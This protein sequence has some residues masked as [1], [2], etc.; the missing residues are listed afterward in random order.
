M[1]V[2]DVLSHQHFERAR[3]CAGAS[4]TSREVTW[5]HVVDQPDPANWVKPGQLVLS[6]GHA[7]IGDPRR[8]WEIVEEL[9][10][11]GVSA[12]VLAVPAY[13]ST[14]PEVM[15]EAGDRL[16]LPL[17]ELPWEVPFVDVTEAL[18][19]IVLSE[20]TKVVEASEEIH[21]KLT[22]AAVSFRGLQD[23]AEALGTL[24]RRAVIIEAA[25]GSLLAHHRRDEAEDEVRAIT[26]ATGRRAPGYLDYIGKLGLRQAISGADG[27]MRVPGTKDGR[28]AARVVCPVKLMSETVGY[29]W[30]I[31]GEAPL[32]DLDLRAAEHAATVAALHI[33]HQRELW[34]TERRLGSTLVDTLLELRGAPESG[35]LERARLEGLTEGSSWRLL[36]FVLALP[37]PLEEAGLRTRDRVASRLRSRLLDEGSFGLVTTS[38][39]FVIAIA[40]E[41][42][43]AERILGDLGLTDITVLVSARGTSLDDVRKRYLELQE[44]LPHVH[45]P[46]VHRHDDYLL[47]RVLAGERQAQAELMK[48][49]LGGLCDV[50]GGDTLLRTLRELCA[51][52]FQLNQAASKLGIHI[53]TLR[54][55]LERLNDLLGHDLNDS[56][57]RFLLQLSFAIL[58][59]GQS[60]E[61]AAGP[62]G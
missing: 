18:H 54:Y 7:F 43:E 20:Q 1:R 6:T 16:G 23:L 33:S 26:I 48:R 40:P 29:V 14:F 27:P 32:T 28:I 38:L 42:V 11:I 21:R 19:R 59:Y 45:V 24:L 22:R 31:E 51:S 39:C 58:Q 46:G 9:D 5:V 4:G 10:K 8:Q 13:F 2:S 60:A 37:L 36:Q 47:P 3:L 15:V 50:R 35:L 61:P 41:R 53:S 55:R 56:A 52:G 12:L 44:M 30:I 25:E 17:I 57:T 34:Q 62:L 49:M